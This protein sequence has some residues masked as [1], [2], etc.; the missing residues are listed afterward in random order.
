[1]PTAGMQKRWRGVSVAVGDEI[2]TAATTSQRITGLPPLVVELLKN[3]GLTEPEAVERF[4]S[5]K[6]QHLIDPSELPGCRDAAER[7]AAAVRD[8]RP[9]VVYGD[10]DVDGVTAAAI[11]W[12]TLRDLGA[13]VRTYVPHRIDEG[14]GLNAEALRGFA[15]E[16]ADGNERLLVITVDCG[17]TAI[18]E[19]TLARELGLELIITDHHQFDAESLPEADGLVHP[20]LS[21]QVGSRRSEVGNDPADT[22][23]EGSLPTSDFALPTSELCGAGVALKL[24]W[25]T[26][27]AFHGSD[28]LPDPLRSLMVNLLALAALGTVADVVPLVGENRVITAYGLS[29]IKSTPFGGLNALIDASKLRDDTIDAYKV[30]FVLGPKLNACG[31]MGHAREA[32]KLLTD[33]TAEEAVELA[34][35]LTTENDRR[36]STERAIFE[37][38]KAMV[39]ERGD[40][41]PDR[42]ALVLAHP[43]WH[44]GVIGIVASRLVDAFHRPTV[45]LAIDPDAGTAKGSARSVDGIDLHAALTACGQHLTK[46]GGHA[47][48]AGLTLDATR[49]DDFRDSLVECI[50]AQLAVD[51]LGSVV[52]I[53]AELALADCCLVVFRQVQ[54]LEPFGRHNPRPRLL[55]RAVQLVRPAQRMGGHGKHLSLSLR[56]TNGDT[57]G[58]GVRAVAFGMGD[59]ADD[60]PAGALVDIVFEPK[61]NTWRGNTTAELHVIDLRV[62]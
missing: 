36:R 59:L 12:H 18:A 15:A 24:A 10:Y 20:A 27:R 16:D 23:S 50:N 62:L 28:R 55:V 41:A 30:G 40:D 49:I 32:V 11:L 47:M 57:G 5:P 22:A 9:I 60:L 45:M 6:L 35:F 38:A 14:Y 29:R 4:L 25:Q 43:D 54:R 53:D 39:A 17:I 26:A 13:N 44:P 31:R 51:D 46:F 33:A 1:M 37:Q 2:D 8:E 3:R 42:R 52:E 21:S 7:I 19:A 56:S 61:L 58:S 48:A 34:K